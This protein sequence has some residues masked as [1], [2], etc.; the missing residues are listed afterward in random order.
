MIPLNKIRWNVKVAKKKAEN[1]C[2]YKFLCASNLFESYKIR[3][4]SFV[5]E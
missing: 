5:P 2:K 3:I 1:M 4:Q